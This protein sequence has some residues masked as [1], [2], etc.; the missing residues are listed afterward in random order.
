[1]FE[2]NEDT[3]IA[4][5]LVHIC[6]DGALG[7]LAPEGHPHVSH[8]ATATSSDGAPV[9]LLSDLAV[10]TKY[11]TNDPR[12]SLLFVSP[13]VD[14]DTNTRA[15]VSLTGRLARSDA[16]HD[17]S[18][19]LRRHP[20]AAL[21]ADFADFTFWRFEIEAAH[22]VAGFGRISDLEAGDLLAPAALADALAATDEGA[23]AH[24]NEDHRDAMEVM[25]TE[26]AGA[27]S[28]DWHAFG[29]DPL[30]IDMA[31]SAGGTAA[32]GGE[33]V[34]VEFD[35]TAADGMAMRKALVAL[36]KR[37][38]AKREGTAPG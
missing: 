13:A 25:A 16:S 23:C 6:R 8:V 38:R 17:R 1:M 7:T 36:T 19:F 12:A 33:A 22:L 37:A 34:R 3:R 20:D 21:Y 10:H 4:R 30:G 14:G 15:R 31:L 18:R 35:T 32:P 24:M 5:N 26:L 29:I 11:L 28:G 9:L 2:S 27:P